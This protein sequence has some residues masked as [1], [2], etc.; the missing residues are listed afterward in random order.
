MVGGGGGMGGGFGGGGGGGGFVDVWGGGGSGGGGGFMGRPSPVLSAA[1]AVAAAAGAGLG[2]MG[3]GEVLGGGGGG[4]IVNI[5]PLP[6][7]LASGAE[8]A[9][10]LLCPGSRT[11]SVIGRGGDV[12]R[13]LRA[14]TSAKIKLLDPVTA[15]PYTILIFSLTLSCLSQNPLRLSHFI[16]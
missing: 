2:Q 6:P 1:A 9:F 8:V 7:T 14:E 13:Q 12:I 16:S 15:G 3:G 4:G 5:M 11:G 10:R